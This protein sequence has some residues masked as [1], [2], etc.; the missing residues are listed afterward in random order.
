MIR[1][2]FNDDE[3][4]AML[5]G[6]N[7]RFGDLRTLMNVLGDDLV[8]STRDRMRRG[9]TPEGAPFAPRPQTTLDIYARKKFSYGL[10]LNRSGDMIR[11]ISFFAGSDFVEVG[12]NER[13]AAVMQF[14]AAKRSFKGVSPW[15]NIPAR[16]DLGLSDQDKTD[17]VSTINTWLAKATNGGA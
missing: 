15:G 1:I 12:S 17:L 5:A 14:G 6:L 13:Q 11:E 10:P 2:D 8:R 3:V 4:Q 16:P 7:R 9:E